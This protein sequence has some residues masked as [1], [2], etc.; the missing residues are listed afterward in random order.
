MEEKKL[1]EKESLEVITS[2]I[3]R[4][5]QRYVG[6]GRIML[7]WGYLVAIVSILVWV[8]LVATGQNNWNYLWFAIPVIG[9]VATPI[10]ARKEQ[11]KSGIKTFS[12]T[13]TSQLWTIAGVSEIAA[14]LACIVIQHL[15]GA[16]CWSAM[17]AYTLITMPVA[18]IAQGLLIKEKSLTI[19]GMAGLAVGIIT[20]CCTAGRIPLGANWYMPMF[21]FAFVAMMIVPGHI[22]NHKTSR[23]R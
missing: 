16:Y 21:I 17:L 6:D 3:A 22:L 19:G 18:E 8:M 23:E 12:D 1:T 15:T 5:R 4:T 11:R 20:V 9:G 13:I 14:I 2:M 7:M 10:M